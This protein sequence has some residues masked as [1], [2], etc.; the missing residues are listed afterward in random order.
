MPDDRGPISVEKAHDSLE[1]PETPR[2]CW[3]GRSRRDPRKEATI[4]L[5]AHGSVIPEYGTTFALGAFR[6][7]LGVKSFAL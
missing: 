7:G 4:D 1:K 3:V 2:H 6:T 5:G